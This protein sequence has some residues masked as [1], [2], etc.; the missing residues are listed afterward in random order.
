MFAMVCDTIEYG[1][2]KTGIRT[3]GLINSA[4]SFGQ[5]IGNGLSQAIFGVILSMGGYVGGVSIQSE[6]AL[7]AI[8]FGY[9]YLPIILTVVQIV[10]LSFY[11]LDKEYS[12][13]LADLK[14]RNK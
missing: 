7:Q 9:I 6:G 4:A 3:E 2:W 5:K 13:I 12:G 10:L 1:E 8:K 11:K 14:V